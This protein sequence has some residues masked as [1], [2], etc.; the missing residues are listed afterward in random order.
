MLFGKNKTQPN[1]EIIS[2]YN[3]FVENNHLKTLEIM[4]KEWQYLL[5]GQGNYTLVF[6]PGIIGKKAVY[7]KYLETL[8]DHYKVIAL[9][10]PIVES[11]EELVLGIH[12]IIQYETVDKVILFGQDFGGIVGQLMV[13]QYPEEID[14]LILM[15]SST[16]SIDVP[17]KNAKRNVT[18]LKRFLSMTKGN[19]YNTFRKKLKKRMSQG[20]MDAG[21][22]N[23]AAWAPFYQQL[24]EDT[25]RGE[26]I[27]CHYCAMMFWKEHRFTEESF[28]NYEGSVLIIESEVDKFNKLDEIKILK[29]MFNNHS[30]LEIKGSR[31]MALERNRHEII[32]KILPYINGLELH[33]VKK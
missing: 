11:L 28:I 22:K 20:I 27:S 3:A 4:G 5:S 24:L 18:S 6:L 1:T 16:N 2:E 30:V 12:K 8:A 26:M 9:D 32:G 33:R 10:Y 15:N 14:A 7:F 13:E 17:K 19:G 29:K 23:P 21:V 25:T 31:N